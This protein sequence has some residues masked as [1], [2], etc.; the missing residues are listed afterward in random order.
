[1]AQP[2]IKSTPLSP[3]EKLTIGQIDGRCRALEYGDVEIEAWNYDFE[4]GARN[5]IWQYL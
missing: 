5:G 3:V 4:H 2:V 1:M